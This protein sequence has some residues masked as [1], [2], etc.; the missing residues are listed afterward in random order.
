M[1][2]A[3][4]NTR[5]DLYFRPNVDIIENEHGLTLIADIPGADEQ[6]IELNYDDGKLTLHAKVASRQP[7]SVQYVLRE[8]EVAD[9]YREFAISEQIDTSKISANYNSGVLT[10]DLPK[11]EAVKPKKINVTVS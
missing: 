9:F 1:A 5:G 4:E 2:N 11:V 7:A 6:G 10:I 8:Y 3:A